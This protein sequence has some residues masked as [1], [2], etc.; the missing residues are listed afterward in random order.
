MTSRC[1]PTPA[2]GARNCR[3]RSSRSA[4]RRARSRTCC[5]STPGTTTA[6]QFVWPLAD[7]ELG[8]LLDEVAA[9]G[10]HVVALLDCCHSG[11]GTRDAFVTA[12]QWIPT[13]TRDADPGVQIRDREAEGPAPARRVPRRHVAA[14]PIDVVDRACRAHRVPI[15]GVG[16]GAHH[17]RRTPGRVHGDDDRGPR[18]S[19]RQG[20]L[21]LGDRGGAVPA[22]THGGTSTAGRASARRGWPRG[23]AVPGRHHRTRSAVVPD[24]EVRVRLVDRRRR[25]ARA[26]GSRRWRGVPVRV[27]PARRHA[28][29]TGSRGLG[30]VRT[31]VGGADGLGAGRHR[32]PGGDLVGA[33][34]DGNRHVRRRRRRC[35]RRRLRPGS[36]GA[37]IERP[38][39]FPVTVR[40][41]ADHRFGTGRARPAREVR[42]R[43][44]RR[45]VPAGAAR[46][47]LTCHPRCGVGGR[48]RRSDPRRADAR[49]AA[50]TRGP[51][52][53][54][55]RARQPSLGPRRCG[56]AEDLP[57][58]AGRGGPAVRSGSLCARR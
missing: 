1:S 26:A 10:A 19:R 49:A 14:L 53:A 22:G 11:D 55:P 16:E 42:G 52:G 43:R 3:P 30:R 7:K 12:R 28:V 32:V 21:P 38:A 9:G 8:L 24:D 27:P 2:T 51:V 57:R 54:A 25:R 56:A 41:R 6:G 47:R 5:C 23:P 40:A 13:S 17:R 4:T 35:R 58:Q 37:G 20:R 46:R 34:A 39:G 15:L 18:D 48:V 29:R 31:G 44:A 33:A 50:G 36:S 45:T